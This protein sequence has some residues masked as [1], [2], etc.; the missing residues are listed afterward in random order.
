LY[1]C[2]SREQDNR[3]H[4]RFRPKYRFLRV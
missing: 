3:I 1:I 2:V 4:I